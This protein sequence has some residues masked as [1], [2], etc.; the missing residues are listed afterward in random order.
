[1]VK[2]NEKIWNRGISFFFFADLTSSEP[3]KNEHKKNKVE[4]CHK[5]PGYR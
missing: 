5:K 2:R 1:M 4:R 3:L